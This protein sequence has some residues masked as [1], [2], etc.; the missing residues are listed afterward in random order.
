MEEKAKGSQE[1]RR[2]LRRV[3]SLGEARA[4]ANAGSIQMCSIDAPERRCHLL[5]EPVPNPS[6]W[7]RTALCSHG[8]QL[9]L[10]I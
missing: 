10:S 8:S 6:A 2:P 1:V 7:V 3:S 9:P 5:Q 4:A